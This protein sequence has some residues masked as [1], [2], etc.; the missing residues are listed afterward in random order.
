MKKFILAVSTAAAFAGLPSV[1][2]AAPAAAPAA[3]APAADPQTTAAVKSMLEAMD[4]RSN[5]IASFAEMEKHMPQMMRS[6]ITS[7]IQADPNLSAEQKQQALAKVDKAL[8]GLVKAV[9]EIFRDPALI[10]EMITEMV[11]LYARNFTT[12]EMNQL[13]EFYRTPLGR[14][15]ALSMPKIASESMMLSQKVMMP[16]MGKLMQG[17]VQELQKK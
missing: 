14:K 10:D 17:I 11:P 12:A 3:A 8:P 6:Q 4:V 2:L 13:A 16:R 9:S 15:M 7:M 5:M 1:V